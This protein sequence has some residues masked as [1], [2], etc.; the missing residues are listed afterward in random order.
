MKQIEKKLH[1]LADHLKILKEFEGKT[2]D[3]IRKNYKDLKFVEKIIQELVDCAI[4]VNEIVIKKV[5]NEK[6]FSSKRSFRDLQDI[7]DKNGIAFED[8]DIKLF[9][10]TVSLRNEIVHSYDVN[11]Y[12]T[13]G[14]R[15]IDV[16]VALYKRYADNIL[17]LGKLIY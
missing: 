6:P 10:D 8:K 4:D 13:W 15:K 1:F 3:E 17:N 11:I 9:I 14:K 5:K 12:L 16:I 2:I 7:C